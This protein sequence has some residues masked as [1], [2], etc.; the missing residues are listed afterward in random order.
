MVFFL[1]VVETKMGDEDPAPIIVKF[2]F[3]TIDPSNR[4]GDCAFDAEVLSGNGAISSHHIDAIFDEEIGKLRRRE[5]ADQKRGK[6]EERKNYKITS[7]GIRFE[8]HK[9]VKHSFLW[10]KWETWLRFGSEGF[11]IFHHN[12]I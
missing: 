11:Q 9:K 12:N 1:I 6:S 4:N 8:I 2:I 3:T 7:N 5:L 10:R